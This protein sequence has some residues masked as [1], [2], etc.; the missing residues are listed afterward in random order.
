MHDQHHTD[1]LIS[2]TQ[3]IE[4]LRACPYWAPLDVAAL[5]VLANA[6]Q[7]HRYPQGAHL[8]AEGDDV[9]EAALHIVASGVI[10]IYK[11]SPDG[12]EQT[13]RLFH[14][15]DSFADV[16]AFDGG[17]YPAH[18]DAMEYSVV[19]LLPRRQLLNLMHSHPAIALGALQVMAGRL[20]HMT[21]LVE[22]LSLRRVSSRVARLL[23][24][25]PATAALSQGQLAPMV[26]SAREMVNR[27]LRS[28]ADAG[29][30]QMQGGD[31]AILDH[32][33]LS[34]LAEQG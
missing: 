12:R 23:V 19:L 8:F 7:E 1:M 34:D 14:T 10:R 32:D 21:G 16:P 31:I 30:V 18:A 29:I 20:R 2:H 9:G 11:L 6:V 3:R 26:G 13:L 15:G 4:L 24:R 33:R 5:D 27:S 28:M 22:D 17:G 25:Q